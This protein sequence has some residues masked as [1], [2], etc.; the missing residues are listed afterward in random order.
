MKITD[1]MTA[2]VCEKEEKKKITDI[3]AVGI[4]ER[5]KKA[6]IIDATTGVH[7]KLPGL[8][9]KPPAAHYSCS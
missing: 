3:M 5:R 2:R 9:E 6:K 8:I 1:I 4:Y 7:K